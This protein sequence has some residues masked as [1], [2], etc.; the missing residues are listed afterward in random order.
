MGKQVLHLTLGNTVVL[1][2]DVEVPGEL[3]PESVNM[4]ELDLPF[5][6]C[7]VG[8]PLLSFALDTISGQKR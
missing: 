6:C 3:E 7:V 5:V 8:Y 1:S 4:G 2:M